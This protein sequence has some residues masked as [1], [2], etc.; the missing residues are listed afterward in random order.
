MKKIIKKP[1]KEIKKKKTAKIKLITSV[2]KPQ[3]LF[4]RKS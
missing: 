1:K 3:T 2:V 4:G